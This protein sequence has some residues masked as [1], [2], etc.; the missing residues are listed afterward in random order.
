MP[1]YFFHIHDAAD[2][3]DEDGLELPSAEVAKWEALRGARGLAAEQVLAGR[4]S[5]NDR[6]DVA[7]ETGAVIATVSFRD[8]VAVEG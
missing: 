1:R 2:L 5:L 6:I 3:I 8:A 7:D 4:L